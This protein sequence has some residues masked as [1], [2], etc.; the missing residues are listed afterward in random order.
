MQFI[1]LIALAFCK[2]WHLIGLVVNVLALAAILAVVPRGVIAVPGRQDVSSVIWPLAPAVIA[3]W[4]PSVLN[5]AYITTHLSAPRSRRSRLAVLVIT[6][7]LVFAV[8]CFGPDRSLVP[9][10]RNASFEIGLALMSCVFLP[11]WSA[12][13]PVAFT[14][15][16][17]WLMGTHAFGPPSAWAILLAPRDDRWASL[18][19]SFLLAIG[20]TMFVLR[21]EPLWS[22]RAE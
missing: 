3:F 7:A 4:V 9:L 13:I 17:M 19:S 11:T 6:C 10:I 18:V 12:W 15:M 1:A 16:V 22:R 5:A 8:L 14:P 2:A 21:R 20:S